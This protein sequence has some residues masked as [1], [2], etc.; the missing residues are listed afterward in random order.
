M[1]ENF[2]EPIFQFV[3]LSEEALNSINLAK[4]TQF[5]IEAYH[6][7]GYSG[8]DFEKAE[9]VVDGDDVVLKA[10]EYSRFM[11]YGRGPGKMPP[12]EP[13]AGWCAKNGIDI[14]PWAI[15]KSI[16]KKGTKGNDFLTPIVP[17]LSEFFGQE[18]ANLI[19][20][21]MTK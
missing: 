14:S 3:S 10:P 17:K 6:G 4:A 7:A 5:V 13:I 16:A 12:I 2:S 20:V 19:G 8:G 1:N 11:L 9:F 15:A 18:I 21:E